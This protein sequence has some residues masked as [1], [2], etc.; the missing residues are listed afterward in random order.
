MNCWRPGEST[1]G[2]TTQPASNTVSREPASIC[3]RGPGRCQASAKAPTKISAS[4][5]HQRRNRRVASSANR[6][7]TA[8]GQAASK[9]EKVSARP[10]KMPDTMAA[11]GRIRGSDIFAA[12]LRQLCLPS[13]ASPLQP[14]NFSAKNSYRAGSP[15]WN[16]TS[17]VRF[18]EKVREGK[19]TWSLPS[20]LPSSCPSWFLSWWCLP[21][22]PERKRS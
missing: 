3:G 5:R 10:S 2:S 13:Q 19:T 8:A 14:E 6:R 11:K 20:C 16:N 15:Q 4:T 17:A 22:C 7:N 21:S 9:L 18:L 1:D 12:A